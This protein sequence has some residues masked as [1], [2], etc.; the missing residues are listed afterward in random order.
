ML[1][2]NRSMCGFRLTRFA[3]SRMLERALDLWRGAPGRAERSVPD[4][5][6]V[7]G[8]LLQYPITPLRYWTESTLRS[9]SGWSAPWIRRVDSLIR[10]DIRVL[11]PL[12]CLPKSPLFDVSSIELPRKQG[13]LARKMP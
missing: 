2:L 4:S 9:V 11:Q 13:F 8:I 6:A 12:V 3:D 7:E 10:F 1:N 5:G